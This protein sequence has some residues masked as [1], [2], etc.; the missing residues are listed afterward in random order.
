MSSVEMNHARAQRMRATHIEQAHAWKRL[1]PEHH[2]AL[3]YVSQPDPDVPSFRYVW[4]S[5][6]HTTMVSSVL[7]LLE[8]WSESTP[9]MREDGS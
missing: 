4:Q 6:V 7:H 1:H 8:L 5:G 2:D 3:D 9:A